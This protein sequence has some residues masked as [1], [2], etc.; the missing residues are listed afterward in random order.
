MD[1]NLLIDKINKLE[2]QQKLLLKII[3]NPDYQFYK[4]VIENSLGEKDVNAFNI[5]CEKMS[6][7]LEEQK[8]EGFVHFHP[9]FKEFIHHLHPS[10]Q[11]DKV[12]RACIK[13]RLFLPLMDEFRKYI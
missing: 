12:V 8:A 4:L 6:K 13:Q 10:F 11:A 7:E 9:L 5:L 1:I 3:E 2:F